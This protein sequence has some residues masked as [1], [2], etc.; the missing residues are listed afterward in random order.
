MF[1]LLN[2]LVLS[3]E[4]YIQLLFAPTEMGTSW[5]LLTKQWL[6]PII[7]MMDTKIMFLLLFCQI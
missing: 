2:I 1:D 3:V 7:N 6:K 4:N 5:I